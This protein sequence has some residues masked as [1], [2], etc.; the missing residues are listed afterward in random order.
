VRRLRRNR[1]EASRLSASQS[2]EPPPPPAPGGAVG[3]EVASVEWP[4]TPPAFT[5]ATTK[6]Y[7]LPAVSPLMVVLGLVIPVL[8]ACGLSPFDDV[9]SYTS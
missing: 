7:A 8:T 5:A 4:E 3:V 1:K 6:K 2:I 9:P